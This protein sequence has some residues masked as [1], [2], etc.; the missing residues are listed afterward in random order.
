MPIEEVSL[1]CAIAVDDSDADAMEASLIE[2]VARAP[3][4]ELEECEAFAKLLKQGQDV[5]DIAKTFGLTERYVKQRLALAS[6]HSAIKDAY[7]NSHIKTEELQLLATA[8][9]RQRKDW[10]AALQ[11]KSEPENDGDGA[12]RGHDLKRWLFGTEQIA[13]AA[14]LLFRRRRRVLG[15]AKRGHRKPQGRLGEQGLER[16]CA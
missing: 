2:N 7:R 13:T 4:D 10:V 14:A 12:P 1:P 16:D 9:R 5:T 11:A 3:M 15:L 6:L 8:T